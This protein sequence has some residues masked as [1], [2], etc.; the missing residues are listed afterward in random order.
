MRDNS[1][2]PHPVYKTLTTCTGC[3]R[4]VEGVERV[5]NANAAC[6]RSHTHAHGHEREREQ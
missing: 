4:G 6:I 1:C 2:F 5:T 3:D